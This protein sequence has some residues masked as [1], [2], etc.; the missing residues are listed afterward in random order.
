MD[1]GTFRRVIPTPRVF[2]KRGEES[3]AIL[4][5][6]AREIPRFA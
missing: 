3:R 1:C 4:E 5:R 2:H 6:T